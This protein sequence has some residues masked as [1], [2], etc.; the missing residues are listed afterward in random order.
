MCIF[1]YMFELRRNISYV[2]YKHYTHNTPC[3]RF[4]AYNTVFC[5]LRILYFRY[6]FLFNFLFYSTRGYTTGV[7]VCT[8]GS[9]RA[10]GG[11][12]GRLE[13]AREQDYF[14]KKVKGRVK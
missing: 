2:V 10:A 9:I 6:N 14:L 11:A 12:F 1:D 3:G 8:A 13:A 7:D 4:V 5:F